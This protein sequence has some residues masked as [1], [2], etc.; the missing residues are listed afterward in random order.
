[1]SQRKKSI[2]AR[3][4]GGYDWQTK[5][6]RKAGKGEDAVEQERGGN[7]TRK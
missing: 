7:T 3:K 5:E 1:M 4:K 6:N 2:L